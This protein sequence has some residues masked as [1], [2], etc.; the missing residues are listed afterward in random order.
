MNSCICNTHVSRNNTRKLP[1]VCAQQVRSKPYVRAR[2]CN[3]KH[4]LVSQRD[5][6]K[7]RLMDII[8]N[9]FRVTIMVV[10]S[11]CSELHDTHVYK[12]YDSLNNA[13]IREL[14]HTIMNDIESCMYDYNDTTIT[15]LIQNKYGVH[16]THS[17]Q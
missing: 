17:I 9:K 6:L 11:T 10:D 5:S 3:N 16:E 1:A 4:A 8:D 14:V 13:N 15:L 12:T 2:G 7:E